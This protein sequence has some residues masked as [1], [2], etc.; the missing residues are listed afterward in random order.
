VD[1]SLAAYLVHALRV[2][3]AALT[4]IGIGLALWLLLGVVTSV[5]G[6]QEFLGPK[7]ALAIVVTVSLLPIFGG[8]Y[9]SARYITPN[10]VLS[11]I[12]AGIVL[13]LLYGW[14]FASGD[15]GALRFGIVGAAVAAAALGAVLGRRLRSPPNNRSRGP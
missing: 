6:L 11:P 12:L 14:A 8:G 13:A 2:L 7:S 15:V 4:M 9:V 3:L 5:L 1:T 10:S